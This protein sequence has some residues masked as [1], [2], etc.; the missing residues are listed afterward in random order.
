VAVEKAGGSRFTS[1]D[2]GGSIPGKTTEITPGID[3]DI[4]GY[5]TMFG[6][7]VKSDLGRLV[8]TQLTGDFDISVQIED[9]HPNK[10]SHSSG[11][12]MVR[13]DLDPSA[14]FFGVHVTT[15]EYADPCDQYSCLYRLMPG[16]S[17]HEPGRDKVG[18]NGVYGAPGFKYSAWG[19]TEKCN[20]SPRPF[21]NVWLRIQRTGN[22]Y[23]G[24]FKAGTQAWAKLGE[25]MH[26]LGA[27]PY[28]GMYIAANE[29]GEGPEN[30]ATVKFRDLRGFGLR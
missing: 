7:H 28:V 29:H 27:Q 3:Y 5:G 20:L 4:E 2:I 22:K 6:N 26:E 13:K 23:N 14:V 12:L 30:K 18:T 25:T 8:Y 15:N 21:P 9:I 17:L 11:G 19:Y 1:V 24:Y 16:G 10:P